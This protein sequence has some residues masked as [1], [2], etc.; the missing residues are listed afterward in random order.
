M[1]NLDPA[2][3]ERPADPA[4]APDPAIP[5]EPEVPAGDARAAEPNGPARD[6]RAAGADGSGG[7]VRPAG[8]A[9]GEELAAPELAARL[10]LSLARLTRLLRQQTPGGLTSSQAS[11]LASVEELE[12]VRLSELA[13]V[14]GVSLPTLSRLVGGLESLNLLVRK[15]DPADGRAAQLQITDAG[16]A[17][18][19]RLRTE[20]SAYL[21]QRLATL[22]P[23][24]RTALSA[25]LDALEALAKNERCTPEAPGV[26]PGTP[27]VTGKS[28]TD[29]L[30]YPQTGAP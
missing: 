28:A 3:P 8:G 24:Q 7:A 21:I 29:T 9:G 4:E 30:G 1:A 5:A 10:R 6:V 20:R 18:L 27:G 11:A 16:R 12:P 14:E 22:E 26:P 13:T 15:P 17:E 19:D 23:G 2:E 25:A